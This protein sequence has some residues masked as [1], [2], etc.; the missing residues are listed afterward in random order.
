MTVRG[1][2][3]SRTSR[4]SRERIFSMTAAL[5]ASRVPACRPSFASTVISS[6][7]TSG[8]ALPRVISAVNW[9]VNQMMGR[10]IHTSASSGRATGLASGRA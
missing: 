7:D 3:M 8:W 4:S 6:T 10:K 2:M 5:P 1:V 9:L